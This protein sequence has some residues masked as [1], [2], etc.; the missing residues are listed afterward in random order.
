MA[1]GFFVRDG[2]DCASLVAAL[3]RAEDGVDAALEVERRTPAWMLATDPAT[4]ARAVPTYREQFGLGPMP[5]SPR[6]DG[7]P[8]SKRRADPPPPRATGEP[9]SP[10]GWERVPREVEEDEESG[11]QVVSLHE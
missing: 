7:A 10:P 3:E 4:G 6:P 2:E 8:P 9:V 5:A 11:F 1:V